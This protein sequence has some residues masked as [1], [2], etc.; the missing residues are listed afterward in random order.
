MVRRPRKGFQIV[1]AHCIKQ[2][3]LVQ[4]TAHW[5][6]CLH[7]S[8]KTC[9]I[10]FQCFNTSLRRLEKSDRA[11]HLSMSYRSLSEKCFKS[12]TKRLWF[13]ARIVPWTRLISY[14]KTRVAWRENIFLRFEYRIKSA[15]SNLVT[16]SYCL[17]SSAWK[18]RLVEG[19]PLP[20]PDYVINT[21]WGLGVSKR[22]LGAKTVVEAWICYWLWSRYWNLCSHRHGF[23]GFL[24][25]IV[26]EHDLTR[27][28]TAHFFCVTRSW[29]YWTAC[30]HFLCFFVRGRWFFPRTVLICGECTS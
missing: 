18:G 21:Y 10:V 22:Q 20:W 28:F 17:F 2:I 9:S 12:F 7:G 6:R 16:C 23:A 26:L 14:R 3:R 25:H 19:R 8:W 13:V 5:W 1:Q 11:K 15:R 29:C 27:S 24:C 4:I 30:C